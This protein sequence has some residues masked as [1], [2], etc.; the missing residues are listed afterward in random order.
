MA[1]CIYH[2]IS[3]IKDKHIDLLQINYPETRAPVQHSPWCTDHN[4]IRQLLTFYHCK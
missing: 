4:V 1:L 2:N 3:F